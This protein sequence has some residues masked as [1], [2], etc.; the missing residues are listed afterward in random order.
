ML[1]KIKRSLKETI[2]LFKQSKK[3]KLKFGRWNGQKT[4]QIEK[5][6]NLKLNSEIPLRLI[7]LEFRHR[8]FEIW[9][10]IPRLIEKLSCW[11]I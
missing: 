4:N 1:E 3:H 8:V 5:F 9:E 6:E 11:R 2:C 10:T 7:S